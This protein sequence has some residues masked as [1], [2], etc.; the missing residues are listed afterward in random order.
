MK[1]PRKTRKLIVQF[2]EYMISGGAWFWV[3][4]GAF[5]VLDK[6]FHIPFWPT[7]ISSY[8]IGASINFLLQKFW[9][10]R[11]KSNK[12]QLGGAAKRYYSLLFLN[13]LL[14]QGIVGGLRAVGVTPYIGQFI[15]SGFFT[16]WNWLWYSLWVF[17][18][19]KPTHKHQHSPVLHRHKKIRGTVKRV[20][21]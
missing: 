21:K 7:K 20:K 1:I 14:D 18:K 4:Y 15:S 17:K 10:F 11:Q 13:F 9:V 16:V 6:V 2:T 19:H 3:G 12:K 8:I 5:A